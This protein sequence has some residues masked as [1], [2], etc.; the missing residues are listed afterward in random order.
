MSI[1]DRLD[2]LAQY[3]MLQSAGPRTGTEREGEGEGE[4]PD[5][6]T[7]VSN[8]GGTTQLRRME[9]SPD[10]RHGSFRPARLCRSAVE[11]LPLLLPD[12][13]P[14][15][16]W[17]DLVF[18]DLETT[19]LS[20]G[21]GTYAFLVG[22]CYLAD[23]RVVLEQF[24]MA[25]PAD[26]PALLTAVADRLARFNHLSTF[27]GKRFDL[28]LLSHRYLMHRLPQLRSFA[29]HH[30][31]LHPARAV[32]RETLSSCALASLETNCL[33]VRRDGDVPG[34]EVPERYFLYLHE[35][36]FSPLEAVMQHNVCD[37]L[38]CITLLQCMLQRAQ[39]AES[40][41]HPTENLA[42]ARRADRAGDEERARNHFERALQ[43]AS[44]RGGFE[45]AARAASLWHKRARRWDDALRIWRQMVQ[46]SENSRW[47]E[48][49]DPFAHV[50]LAKYF[51]HQTHR[52]DLALRYTERAIVMVRRAVQAGLKS[53]D[54]LDDLHHRRNR[55]QRR[56]GIPS[57]D[58]PHA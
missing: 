42:L 30:D 21:A 39:T 29:G 3:G 5:Y 31:L 27:N 26:E 1:R 6:F 9:F 13:Q 37:L 25:D 2:R 17:S 44:S 48:L 24:F 56:L 38:S 55:L 40:C 53:P 54:A 19:G 18:V 58:S 22:M 57:A 33:G 47:G 7:P 14:P 50:E 52:F 28:P 51:E 46:R 32:W 16:T 8:E 49:A 35:G 20:T 41:H 12:E 36:R 34:S 23:D 11:D 43:L 10:H 15:E 4:L 45:R